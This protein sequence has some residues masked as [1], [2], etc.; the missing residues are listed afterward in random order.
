M[1]T[2]L[3]ISLFLFALTIQLQA[4]TDPNWTY[5]RSDNTGIGGQLHF[6]IK[7]DNFNNVWT[8]GYTSSSDEGSL[9]RIATNDTVYT[10]WGT[11]AEN[12]LPN[13]LIFDIDFDHTGVIWVG[14]EKGI[15]TSSDGLDWQHFDTTNSPLLADQ[16]EAMAIGL[17]ND[18]WAVTTNADNTVNGIGFYNG[19]QW[20]YYTSDNSGLPAATKFNDIAIDGN[21]VKWIASE[22]GLIKYD[23]VD[24]TAFNTANS[25]LS[26][27]NIREVV[28]DDQDRVWSLVGNAVDIF[29]GTDWT[30]ITSS[31]LPVSNLNATSIAIR[32]DKIILTEGSS[33]RSLIFDGTD[34][35]A[36]TTN[37]TIFDCYIDADGNYWISGSGVV[38]KFDGI[39]WTRYTR[40]N[41]GLP[42][43]FNDDI[44]IDSQ[45]RRWFANG[46]GGIQVFDCPNWE[47][48]GPNNEG[49]FPNP[50][51][52]YQT[53]IG[54]SI[55]EDAD[56]DIWFTYDGTSGYAIQVPNGNYSDYASWVIW[57]NTTAH[58]NLQLVQEV[59]A[60]DNGLVF[61][62]TYYGNTF[63]YDKTADTWTQW[64]LSNGLTSNP[65]CMT[66]R[67]G[68]KMYLGHYQGI[69]IYDNDTWSRMDLSTV[70]IE[71]VNDIQF[72]SND[73]MWVAT[74]LGLWKYDGTDWT[75]WNTTNSNIAADNVRAIDIDANNNIYISAHNTHTYPYYGGISYFEGTGN[76]FTTFLAADS[77]L[78]HKQ[79]EDIAVD[80]F[81]NIWALT[82]SEGFSIYNPNGISGFKCIDRTLERTLGVSGFALEIS[83]KGISYPNPFT[84][85]T[86]ISFNVKDTKPVSINIY[87]VL[88]RRVKRFDLKKPVIGTNNFTLDLSNQK[89][90]IY[91]CE[92]L[93]SQKSSTIKLLK[94]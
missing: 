62:R 33:S 25:G 40:N 66:A 2:K 89:S 46:G 39:E 8:G 47:V 34:W 13:G 81:G 60:T 32:G 7:G 42:D 90:G 10:N 44:F 12:Y 75:N 77:P 50:Q 67:S 57:D 27:N 28:I 35:I 15:A 78:A 64:D 11:Y 30:H 84:S 59:E 86:T 55:T 93:S 19:I 17:N 48:Y 56:G 85:T 49:L 26:S 20:E 58:P 36:E 18:L 29:D 82:Q 61:L 53:T 3:L 41:T 14:T 88:G 70:G 87:D 5:I 6:T 83:E 71:H 38:S 16:T 31:E 22:N 52:H 21:D 54:T 37:F 1:K 80:E 73:V 45:G 74:T 94:K 23:G 43:N 72:D 63:M 65:D 76:T 91:F 68:G 4:Q 9:V 51:P 69:D 79:V 24:W 92:I